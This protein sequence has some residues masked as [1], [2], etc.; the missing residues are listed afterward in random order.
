MM[1]I[2]TNSWQIFVQKKGYSSWSWQ[3][4][5]SKSEGGTHTAAS[6]S[7]MAAAATVLKHTAS[8]GLSHTFNE[9]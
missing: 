6:A 5:G 4:T 2:K 7:R 8:W 3:G 1:Q 9:K